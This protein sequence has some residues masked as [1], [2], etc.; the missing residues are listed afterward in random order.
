[1]ARL[2]VCLAALLGVAHPA[3]AQD[4]T[5][6][7]RARVHLKAGET[8][9]VTLR[10]K[11]DDLAIWGANQE[12]AVEPGEFTVWV[13]GDSRATLNEKFNLQ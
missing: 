13:G 2:V 3:V 9:T 7:E 5:P 10:I 11:H 6:T 1:M 8:K 4:N 12:W